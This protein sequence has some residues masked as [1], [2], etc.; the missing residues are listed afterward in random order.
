[1][2]T[3]IL[4]AFAV[5]SLAGSAVSAAPRMLFEG[6]LNDAQGR[7]MSGNYLLVF[8]VFDALSGGFE[9]WRETQY[10]PVQRGAFATELGRMAPL[11]E[12]VLTDVHRVA[13]EAPF[14][15]PWKPVLGIAKVRSGPAAEPPAVSAE[16][17]EQIERTE[18]VRA[19]EEALA[20]A[21][22][23]AAASDWDV[24]RE[25]RPDDKVRRL[26]RDL[27]QFRKTAERSKK[28]AEESKSRLDALEK[29]L[30][31]KREEGGV[32]IYEVQPGDTLRSIAIK[33][34]GDADRWVELYEANHDRLQRGGDPIAGQR[35]VAP[36]AR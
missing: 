8:K 3:K 21:K 11:P 28:E 34:Y 29:A 19:A 30:K 17:S 24:R 10:V 9:I 25:R 22:A 35:L 18:G 26:E 23:A 6:R 32:R 16:V 5:L 14:G 1:M 20:K 12:K 2:R 7:P 36:R 15:L 4:S 13:V 27:E 33:L 31:E